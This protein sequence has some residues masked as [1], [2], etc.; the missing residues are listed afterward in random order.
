[1]N[2]YRHKHLLRL[3]AEHGAASIPQLSHW[4][5]VSAATVRRDIRRWQEVAIG[6]VED[7]PGV[8]P[9][10]GFVDALKQFRWIDGAGRVVRRDE[11]QRANARPKR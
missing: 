11:G 5:G 3:L 2:Q 1:M 9:A 8:V 7:Q 4:L 6:L 10:A